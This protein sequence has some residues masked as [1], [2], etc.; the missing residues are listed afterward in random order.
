MA[1]A[2][3]DI[4]N[5]ALVGH[6]HSGKTAVVDALAFHGKLTT[7]QGNSADGSSLSNSEPEEKERKQ[8]L[9]AHLF[10][11][12]TGKTRIDLIDT[13]GHPDFVADTISALHVVET[14]CLC[15]S[16][17]GGITFHAR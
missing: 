17:A 11:V 7:R 4:R 1:H 6:G 14:V 16:A 2:P 8:T 3:E 9:S 15:V 10:H 12:P 13:P 5:L